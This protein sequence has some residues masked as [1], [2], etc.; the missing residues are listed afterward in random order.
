MTIAI[1]CRRCGGENVSRDAWAEWDQ[2]A[3]QWTLRTLFDHGYCHD[4]D[5]EASLDE[6][7][8][9]TTHE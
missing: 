8:L 2:T 5:T 3:Q 4:C 7:P 9:V 6:Q 1:T